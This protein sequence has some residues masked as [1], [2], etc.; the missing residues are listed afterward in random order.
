MLWTSRKWSFIDS[1]VRSAELHNNGHWIFVSI[2]FL[3]DSPSGQGE[4]S[5][6]WN[7]DRCS[8][9]AFAD[10][11]S[12]PHHSHLSLREFFKWVSLCWNKERILVAARCGCHKIVYLPEWVRFSKD[13]STFA[14]QNVFQSVDSTKDQKKDS[15][16]NHRPS[17]APIVYLIWYFNFCFRA[18]CFPQTV[19]KD[20]SDLVW[21]FSWEVQAPLSEN[22]FSQ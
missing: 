9:I 16:L 12:F 21:T 8:C 1:N 11:T 20:D 6:L 7:V 15:L 3:F 19:Q 18:K 4:G 13:F 5:Q 14:P 2:G 10:L 22:V 17:C